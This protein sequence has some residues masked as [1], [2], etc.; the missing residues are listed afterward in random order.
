MFPGMF[1]SVVQ[2]NIMNVFADERSSRSLQNIQ[3]KH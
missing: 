1:S 2:M 3:E